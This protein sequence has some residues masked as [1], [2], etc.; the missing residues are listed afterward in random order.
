MSKKKNIRDHKEQK[1]DIDINNKGC[2]HEILSLG[3][4]STTL[5]FIIVE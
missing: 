1:V 3:L 2:Q 4:K 5:D